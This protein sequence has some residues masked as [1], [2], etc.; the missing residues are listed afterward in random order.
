[1]KLI[2]GKNLTLGYEDG[3]IVSNLNFI[4][5]DGDWLSVV[6][7]NGSGKT[8]FVKTLLGLIPP[9]KGKLEFKNNLKERS[10]GYLPQHSLIQKDFPSSCME[11]VLSGL[12]NRT[13]A[14]LGYSKK[15]KDEAKMQLKKLKISNL[16]KKS[17]QELS[18]GQQQKVLLARALMAGKK[19]L[20][21]DE[22]ST[23][24]DLKST[25]ELYEVLNDLRE[26]G[27][28]IMMVTH[29]IHPLINNS[30]KV[31]YFGKKSSS[32]YNRDVFLAT[33]EGKEL[34]HEAGHYV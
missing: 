22:P 28:T 27:I 34:L 6:G 25:S 18:G 21:L 9:L 12:L 15:E 5:E 8:T 2:E 23:G 26:H 30:N 16:E 31:L 17:F 3:S 20:L 4:L 1:M 33:E 7:E 14:F 19:L 13:H 10:I 32:F 24:L 11:I 29:D